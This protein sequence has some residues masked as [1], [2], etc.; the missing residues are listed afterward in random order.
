MIKPLIDKVKVIAN[1]WGEDLEPPANRTDLKNFADRI[2][3]SYAVDLPLQYENF[4]QIVNGLEFN[5]LIIYG[6]K[7]SESDPNASSLDFFEMNEV[8]QESLR[9]SMLN[10]IFVGENST[11]VL[12]YEKDAKQFQYR[13]RIGLDRI[14][15][16]SS[17]EEML[18]VE[19]GKVI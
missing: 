2:Q 1:G 13:D 19:I 9:A 8:L 7:N 17:F 6:T 4:L 12:T 14:E 11:G 5:G 10:V 16:Y 18:K 15:P 3:Q